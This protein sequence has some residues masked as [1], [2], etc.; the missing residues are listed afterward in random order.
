MLL[1]D[2]PDRLP[3]TLIIGATGTGKTTFTRALL[4]TRP[5]LVAVLTP[6]PDPADWPGAPIIT[7]GDAGDFAELTQAFGVLGSEV[8]ARLVA[9]KHQQHPGPALTI[10]CD[11]WP[12]LASECGR[13]ATDL[14]KLVARL[15]R[16]LRVRLIVLSQS[17]RVR[18]LG[19][20]GEGDATTNFARVTLSRGHQAIL[21]TE[22]QRLPLDTHTVP[23]LAATPVSPDRWWRLSSVSPTPPAPAPVVV[24][25]DELAALAPFQAFLTGIPSV[26]GDEEL[27]RTG[28][29]PPDGLDAETIKALHSA[30]W[31]MNRIAAKMTR[32]N[33]QQRLERIRQALGTE[34]SP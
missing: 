21:E 22:G 8:R 6:K 4:A 17:E 18:S 12:V 25:G 11:D 13:P 9:A 30:G 31:S 16:S 15:G 26:T 14:F 33:K 29:V 19:L 7:I 28:V 34:A 3:H 1:N 5:G 23:Q 2:Q 32:G 20:D 10:I 27:D 24:T